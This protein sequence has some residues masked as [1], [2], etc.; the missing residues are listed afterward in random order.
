LLKNGDQYRT[1]AIEYREGLR[2]P[3][4]EREP[5]AADLLDAIVAPRSR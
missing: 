4:L 3:H 1:V 2:Y 5:A